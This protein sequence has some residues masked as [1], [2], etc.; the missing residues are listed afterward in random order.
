VNSIKSQRQ[1]QTS[2]TLYLSSFPSRNHPTYSPSH[3]LG[4]R[5]NKL[6]LH[7][8]LPNCLIRPR[9][10]SN[11]IPMLTPHLLHNQPTNHIPK[12]QS[13]SRIQMRIIDRH[14]IVQ[15]RI[16]LPDPVQV[17]HGGE[18]QIDH[19]CAAGAEGRGYGEDGYALG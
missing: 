9:I 10:R 12:H 4:S 8:R 13:P 7:N 2:S 17:R 3:L 19:E 18:I 15:Q 1:F 16:V 14:Q 5:Q 11:I 6:P